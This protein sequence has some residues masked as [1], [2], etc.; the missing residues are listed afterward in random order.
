MNNHG[1]RNI[2][3]YSQLALSGFLPSNLSNLEV[4]WQNDVDV[5]LVETDEVAL[6]GDQTANMY[7][8][9]PSTTSFRGRWRDTFG[10]S[11]K[12]CLDMD[13]LI[14]RYVYDTEL[15]GKIL[16][17]G[18]QTFFGL[19]ELTTLDNQ[20]LWFNTEDTNN[21]FAIVF[22]NNYLA[23]GFYDGAFQT[24]SSDTTLGVGV[25]SFV[26]TNNNK[27]Q[28]LTINGVSH[29]GTQTTYQ[30]TNTTAFIVWGSSDALRFRGRLRDLGMYS[31]VKS[32]ADVDDI[33]AYLDSLK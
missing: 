3:V 33:N 4:W 14:A 16:I 2:G 30:Q 5:A 24:I 19:I 31:D 6:W 25:Y 21:R 32:G 26:F 29:T 13:G 23:F 15:R 17:A 28:T 27:V 8:I 20:I 18:T 12:S 7:D 11:N 9:T 1:I 10:A 22:K